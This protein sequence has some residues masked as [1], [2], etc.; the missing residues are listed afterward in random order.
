MFKKTILRYGSSFMLTLGLFLSMIS[1]GRPASS[2]SSNLPVTVSPSESTL[3][4]STHVPGSSS[5]GELDQHVLIAYFTLWD[6]APWGETVDSSTSA[7]VVID[8]GDPV[9]TNAYLARMIQQETGGDLH[10]ILAQE[11]YPAN[12]QEVIDINHAEDSRTISDQVE[13]MAQYDTVLLVY[14]VWAG[15]VPQVIRTFLSSYDLT[16]KTV[17]P[18]CTHN[19]Y[20]AARS[21]STVAELAAGAQV[22]EGLAIE[23]TGVTNAQ[24]T[25]RQR[26]EELA[27]TQPEENSAGTALRITVNGQMV[28]GILYDST[29]AEQFLA[30]LPQTISMSNYGG[31][32]VYGPL[33]QTISAEGEGQLFFADGDITYCPT[34]QTAAI[35]Y[36]QS[37]RPNLT[38]EVYPIG[39]VTSGLSLFSD[40]PSRVDVTFEAA[41]S[42]EDNTV[43]IAYFTWADNASAEPSAVEVDNITSA[44]LVSPGMTG[45]MA[46]WIQESVGGDLFSIQTQE[47]Y[48]SDY[49]TCL[50]RAT[51]EA[52][53]DA[54][55]A[56]ANFISDFDQYDTIF[57]GYPIWRGT[58]PMAVWTFLDRYDFIGKTVIPF[59]AHGTSGLANSIQDIRA[60]LPGANVLNG[61]GV[62]RP[63][64]DTS[65]ETA[66]AAVED[67]LDDL[68]MNMR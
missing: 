41:S 58:C 68:E 54:R 36:S 35:F 16:G 64:L 33:E 4:N 25:V 21:F 31:R 46:A 18:V 50:A 48:S 23:S 45:Q 62:Q 11:P 27:L 10:A 61:I 55:P 37:D 9:G 12:F 57:L 22:L 5:S 44:S 19:G 20:G 30:Q 29:M 28:E 1:C 14:P 38:M 6:N 7:S 26:L 52:A 42:Q 59:C 63:G 8:Q 56:L 47:A 51:E 53:S 2:S 39:R 43:L 67:W 40:L 34:N 24:E 13:N 15:D 49:E 17:L 60:A 66:R 32:E 65:L 3:E